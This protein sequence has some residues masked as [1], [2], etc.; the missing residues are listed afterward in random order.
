MDKFWGVTY[1]GIWV[2][3][4]LLYHRLLKGSSITKKHT[5]S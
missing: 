2:K 1:R 5:L 4:Y 3:S